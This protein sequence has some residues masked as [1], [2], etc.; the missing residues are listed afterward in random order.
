M[1]P[2]RTSGKQVCTRGPTLTQRDTFGGNSAPEKGEAM[3]HHPW[4]STPVPAQ[5]THRWPSSRIFSYHS[6]ILPP[7]FPQGPTCTH[8]HTCFLDP[9]S[10]SETCPL[11]SLSPRCK[12]TH[13]QT[14]TC[15]PF[16]RVPPTR[17]HPPACFLLLRT[18]FFPL[19]TLLITDPRRT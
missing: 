19:S 17:T 15:I 2:E 8:A 11:G 6:P 5:A 4:P 10:A 1:H 18:S 16:T 12:Q 3:L 9:S 14:Q 7:V 13:K